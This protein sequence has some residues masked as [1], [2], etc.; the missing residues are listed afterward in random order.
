M[1]GDE[2]IEAGRGGDCAGEELVGEGP[3]F[4]A[5]RAVCQKPFSMAS[6][7]FPVKSH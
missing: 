4:C 1:L 2:L 5:A 6:V 3:R 7:L